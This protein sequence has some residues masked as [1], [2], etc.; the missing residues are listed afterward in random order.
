MPE[1][2]ILPSE[3]RKRLIDLADKMGLYLEG[4]VLKLVDGNGDEPFEQYL[5]EAAARDLVI[6]SKRLKITKQIQEQNKSLSALNDQLRLTITNLEQARDQAEEALRTSN[7][8]NEGIAQFSWM[9]SHNLRG[10]IASLLGIVNLM[11]RDR[12]LPPSLTSMVQLLQE[13]TNKIDFKIKEI[14]EVLETHILK[15][16]DA[17]LIRLD[18]VT[19]EIYDQCREE[20]DADQVEFISGIPQETVIKFALNPLKKILRA[21]FE[22]ALTFRREGELHQINVGFSEEKYE[23][24]IMISDNG[25]GMEENIHNRIFEPFKVFSEKSSGRGMGLYIVKSLLESVN[26]RVEVQSTPGEGSTFI[27]IMP[28]LH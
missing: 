28:V 2:I 11:T 9:L 10:P 15:P 6:R 26:G 14:S 7:R 1:A 23:L 16:E 8:Q 18:E 24:H 27:L 4:N 17:E 19:N 13:T 22:N 21:L 3:T 12:S 25:I 20:L 5:K